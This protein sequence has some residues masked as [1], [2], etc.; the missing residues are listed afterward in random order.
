M[1][2]LKPIICPSLLSGDFA[3]LAQESNRMINNGANWLHMD[4]MVF[5]YKKVIQTNIF[6]KKK[7][8]RMDILS[9]I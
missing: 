8:K 2:S 9:P 7:K 3:N 6:P 1:T 5:F 4:V